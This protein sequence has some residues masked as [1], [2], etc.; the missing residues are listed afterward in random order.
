MLESC[1][2]LLNGLDSERPT[3]VFCNDAPMGPSALISTIWF[4]ERWIWDAMDALCLCGEL[5]KY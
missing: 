3:S 4:C 2:M 5:L 1:S